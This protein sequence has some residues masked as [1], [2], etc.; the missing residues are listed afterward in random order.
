MPMSPAQRSGRDLE[1]VVAVRQR[2]GEALVNR[3]VLGEP[4]R[5]AVAGEDGRVAQVL[6]AGPAEPAR[7]AGAAQPG[8]SHARA[9]REPGRCRTHGLDDAHDLVTG[10][11]RIRRSDRAHR[12]SRGDRSG[13]P[14]SRARAGA[15]RPG[16]APAPRPR[17]RRG[18]VRA[19][20]APWRASTPERSSRLPGGADG[21]RAARRARASFAAADH[22]IHSPRSAQ[23]RGGGRPSPTVSGTL[24]ARRLHMTD[25]RPA[26]WAIILAGRAGRRLSPLTRALYEPPGLTEEG[27]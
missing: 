7:A 5:P 25:R 1:V 27:E 12:R 6:P 11:H 9:D 20:P 22:A 10:D 17:E 23:T 24:C 8:R 19:P 26:L 16:R 15:P 2:K 21:R 13:K 4:S 14:R 18:D 3:H